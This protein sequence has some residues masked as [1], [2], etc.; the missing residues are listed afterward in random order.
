MKRGAEARRLIV[1]GEDPFR[2]LL[3]VVWPDQDWGEGAMLAELAACPMCSEDA[4]GCP[5]CGST[6]LVTSE[7][8]EMLRFEA[9]ADCAYDAA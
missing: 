9:L 3:A 5:E 1:E 8:R 4:A 6:G 2:M 7:R